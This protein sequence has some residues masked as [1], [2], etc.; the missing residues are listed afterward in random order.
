M[1]KAVIR[2]RDEVNCRIEGL[3]LSTRKRL[4]NQFSFMINY[5]YHTPAYKLG[6]WDGKVNFFNIG[7][8]T[9]INLLED[10]LPVLLSEGYTPV[11]ED[12][13]QP[14][15][16]DLEEIDAEYFSSTLWPDGH[17]N[18]GE[19]IVIREHQIDCINRAIK[20]L[21]SVQEIATGA[22]KTII[23]AALSRLVEEASLRSID[24]S[25]VVEWKLQ[26][27]RDIPIGRTIVI[28]PNKDL[29]TQTE[30]DYIN[31]GLDVG[32]YYGDR[33]DM[34]NTHTIC[35]WQS[36]NSM[37]KRFKD[38]LSDLN[39]QDFS[40]GVTALIVDECFAPNTKILTPH[41]EVPISAIKSGDTVI[42]YD[43][44]TSMFKEDTV[45]D[46][47]ENM[48]KSSSELMYELEFDDGTLIQVTG[49]HKFLTEHHGWIRAD[50]LT[51]EMTVKNIHTLN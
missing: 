37:D 17:P 13:R 28:V 18:E 1:S 26:Y 5:A 48:K 2:L 4:N 7:G 10:I 32:V 34:D 51:E 42:N 35:T 27:G 6:R 21:Q 15:K 41:G 3:E 46:V 44:N 20:N 23:T 9:Y 39:V 14:F 50:E 24:E 19:P 38:G 29:V 49:N 36:L 16:I 8:S 45:V 30:A 33:K 40:V 25:Q 12:E 43:E 11:V 31:L 22:G 47:F